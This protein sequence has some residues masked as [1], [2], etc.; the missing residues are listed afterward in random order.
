METEALFSLSESD[1][2]FLF[3]VVFDFIIFFSVNG[4]LVEAVLL[5]KNSRI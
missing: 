4:S 1:V 5:G 2:V 3:G